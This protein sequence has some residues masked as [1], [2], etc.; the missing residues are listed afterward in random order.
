MKSVKAP[1]FP[2]DICKSVFACHVFNFDFLLF[3]DTC[4]EMFGIHTSLP[5]KNPWKNLQQFPTKRDTSPEVFF[6]IHTS[7]KMENIYNHIFQK[8]LETQSFCVNWDAQEHFKVVAVR[9]IEADEEL[10]LLLV[11]MGFPVGIEG[12]WGLPPNKFTKKQVFFLEVG[13]VRGVGSWLPYSLQNLRKLMGW[14]Q[15]NLTNSLKGHQK[16]ACTCRQYTWSIWIA[17]PS[18]CSCVSNWGR[19]SCLIPK[20]EPG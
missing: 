17:W 6:L 10:T 16:E 12:R 8:L 11:V 14:L 9:D 3:G 2:C 7:K 5:T 13:V 15:E 4:F 20:E 1:F 19:C 18:G